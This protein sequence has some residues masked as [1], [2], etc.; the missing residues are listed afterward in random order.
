MTTTSV[1]HVQELA[2]ATYNFVID[3]LP[4][5]I[6]PIFEFLASLNLDRS[7]YCQLENEVSAAING[8][9]HEAFI[10]GFTMSRALENVPLFAPS[11]D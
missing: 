11:G 3:R 2:Q 6:T 7:V 10:A 9:E 4:D 5:H 8:A 1:T